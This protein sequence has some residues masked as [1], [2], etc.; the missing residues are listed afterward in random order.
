MSKKHRIFIDGESGTTGLQIKQRLVNHPGIEIVSIAPEL[1]KDAAAK[2]KLMSEVEVVVL[3][4][5]DDAAKEAAAQAESLGCKI[6]DPSSAHRVAEGW[7]FGLP[8]MAPGQREAIRAARKISNPGCYAT[9]AIV[10]LRPLVDAGLIPTDAAYSINAVSGYTGGGKKMIEQYENADGSVKSDA[11]SYVLYGLDFKHKHIP[12][13]VRWSRLKTRP[14]FLPAV[15]PL[16]QGMLVSVALED[17][18]GEALHAAYAKHYAGERFVRLR[19]LGWT[20]PGT[21]PY[22]EPHG[23]E[24]GNYVDIHVYASKEFKRTVVIAKLDN[25][26]RGASG[27]AVQNLNLML[28]LPEETAVGL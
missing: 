28:G 9:G 21:A 8:E 25:L 14:F 10:L 23:T 13:I 2:A 6:L 15:V 22:L 1:R 3:C 27:T 16:A 17:T 26:G 5:P 24:G 7:V 12:E 4:L 20:D 19:E 18:D 11:P